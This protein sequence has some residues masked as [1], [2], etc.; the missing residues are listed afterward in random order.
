MAKKSKLDKKLETWT[1]GFVLIFGAILWVVDIAVKV[2]LA[3]WP[4]LLVVLILVIGFYIYKHID[5][6]KNERI[7]FS[8]KSYFDLYEYD[9][10]AAYHSTFFRN[11]LGEYD[12]DTVKTWVT[13]ANSVLNEHGF[14]EDI[15]DNE[16]NRSD[17]LS[18]I[19]KLAEN[20]EKEGALKYSFQTVNSHQMLVETVIAEMELNGWNLIQPSSDGIEM[21]DAKL[22]KN[23]HSLNLVC[24]YDIGKIGVGKIRKK[25]LDARMEPAN[26]IALV[27]PNGF[28]PQATKLGAESGAFCIAPDGI[29]FLDNKM[30]I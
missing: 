6:T 1:I 9:L 16:K 29:P 17:V 27:S 10:M 19:H 8:V 3:L 13:A 15:T 21:V 14:P 20:H 24:I 26:A 7:E 30:G 2:F 18:F 4:V 25:I 28:T 22:E 5:K 12:H 23:G 11:D